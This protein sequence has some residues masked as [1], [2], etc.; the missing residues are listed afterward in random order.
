MGAKVRPGCELNI[1]ASEKALLGP[2]KFVDVKPNT[3]RMIRFLPPASPTLFVQSAN[4]YKIKDQDGRG[5]ALAC[6]RMHGTEESGTACWVCD[7]IEYLTNSG[8]KANEQIAKDLKAG[9]KDYAQVCVGEQQADDTWKYDKVQLLG[10]NSKGGQAVLD[11]GKRQKLIKQPLFCDADNGRSV[12][13]TRTG[14]G[15]NTTYTAQACDT[16]ESLDSI[17]PTWV[18]EYFHDMTAALDLKVY[19]RDMQRAYVKLTFADRLDWD[20]IGAAGL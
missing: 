19:T 13:I 2:K 7:L 11:V 8:L 10:I 16:P 4:H 20:A 1:E 14:S 5:I 12:L 15:F 9:L 18:D 6:L 3:T 17:R